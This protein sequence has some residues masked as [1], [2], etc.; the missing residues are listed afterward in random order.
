M[1]I[2]CNHKPINKIITMS[3]NYK[4]ENTPNRLKSTTR[5]ILLKESASL[6][7]HRNTNTYRLIKS[8]WTETH[9]QKIQRGW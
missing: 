5:V 3:L 7:H 1:M 2:T 9:I 8:V 4:T 6:H